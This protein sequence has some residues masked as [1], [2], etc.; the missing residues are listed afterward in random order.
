MTLGTLSQTVLMSNLNKSRV[1]PLG[2]NVTAQHPAASANQMSC[3]VHNNSKTHWGFPSPVR[4]VRFGPKVSEPPNG[5][6]L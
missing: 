3:D 1:V 2:T 5:I 6:I 4:F